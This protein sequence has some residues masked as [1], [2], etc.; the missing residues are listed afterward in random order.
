MIFINASCYG[1]Y[2]VMITPLMR[3]YHP[4][5]VIKWVFLFGTLTV[6]PFGW[7]EFLEIDFATMPSNIIWATLYVVFGL[8]FFAYLLNIVALKKWSPCVGSIYVYLQP[9]LAAGFAISFGKDELTMIKV[10]AAFLICSG[11]YL[12]STKPKTA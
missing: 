9:L 10:A 3:K 5:T 1:I 2:L 7:N 6:L 11:V 4:I 12:V 8:S